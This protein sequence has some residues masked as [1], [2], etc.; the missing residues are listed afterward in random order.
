MDRLVDLALFAIHTCTHDVHILGCSVLSTC[1]VFMA[2]VLYCVRC[3]VFKYL[4]QVNANCTVE[5][6]NP[7]SKF[8][9]MLI[10]IPNSM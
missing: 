5:T 3:V 7:K 9:T 1:C 8:M 6:N 10:K 2:F 4:V